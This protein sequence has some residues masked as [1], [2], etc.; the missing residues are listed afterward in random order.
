VE[1]GQPVE[2][3]KITYQRVYTPLTDDQQKI[4]L[5]IYSSRSIDPEYIDETDSLY[6]GNLVVDLSDIA[7]GRDNSLV[8]DL[9]YF[10]W[11]TSFHMFPKSITTVHNMI[12]NLFFLFR[13]SSR[14]ET[15]VCTDLTRIPPETSIKNH[16]NKLSNISVEYSDRHLLPKQT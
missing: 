4:R 13:I 14:T 15:F 9:V 3:D 10:N 6:L 16:A 1:R 12:N 11:L 2:V 8:S 5:P 7:G